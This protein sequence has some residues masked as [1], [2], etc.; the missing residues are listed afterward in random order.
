MKNDLLPDDLQGWLVVVAT[1]ASWIIVVAVTWTRM[2]DKINGVGERV[3]T[4]E[5]ANSEKE[6][7]MMRYE[8]E[9][10]EARR[11]SADVRERLGRVEKAIE[12]TNEHITEMKLEVAGTLGEIKNM[13]SEK[14]AQTR[15]R[16]A[17]IETKQRGRDL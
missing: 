6:G 1:I 5:T 7:R 2:T 3:K 16:L 13:I 15:E 17:I 12:G 8:T 14:D 4:L 11:D 9:L 10:G